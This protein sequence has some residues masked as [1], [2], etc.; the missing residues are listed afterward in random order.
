MEDNGDGVVA[1]EYSVTYD[2]EQQEFPVDVDGEEGDGGAGPGLRC[3]VRVEACAL[4]TARHLNGAKGTVVSEENGERWG[5][6]FDD[7]SLG[8]KALRRTNLRRIGG[9]A[10]AM[11]RASDPDTET[12]VA[13]SA[14]PPGGRRRGRAGGAASAAQCSAAADQTRSPPA[15]RPMR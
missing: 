14:W 15:K 11:Q 7:S 4:E 2:E 10:E 6:R 13:T 9:Y 3:G 1:D 8:E 12:D 5:V